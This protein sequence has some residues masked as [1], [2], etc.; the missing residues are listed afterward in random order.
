MRVGRSVFGTV[1]II[2]E[3][4][5]DLQ[6]DVSHLKAFSSKTSG[7]LLLIRVQMASFT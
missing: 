2:K 3:N 1:D 4:Y 7:L 5:K 6:N